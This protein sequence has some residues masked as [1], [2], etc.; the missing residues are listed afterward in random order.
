MRCDMGLSTQTAIGDRG[1]NDEG[2]D[3]NEGRERKGPVYIC[4]SLHSTG[5]KTTH[6]VQKTLKLLSVRAGYCHMLGLPPSG[7][8]VD[9]RVGSVKRQ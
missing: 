3:E 6:A 4:P 5:S 7:A 8:D 1:N 2:N 9:A